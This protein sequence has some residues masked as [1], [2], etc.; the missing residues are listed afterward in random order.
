MRT[1]DP[2]FAPGVLR[3]LMLLRK[4]RKAVDLWRLCEEFQGGAVSERSIAD[5]VRKEHAGRY[6]AGI[7]ADALKIDAGVLYSGRIPRGYPGPVPKDVRR[8]ARE[9]AR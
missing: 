5:A 6:V 9:P 1:S 4:I 3:R 7:I 8:I 2:P